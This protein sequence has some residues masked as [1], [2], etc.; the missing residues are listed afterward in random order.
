MD[1]VYSKT[2]LMHP[3][4][5]RPGDGAHQTSVEEGGGPPGELAVTGELGPPWHVVQRGPPERLKN[6][7][8]QAEWANQ[9]LD[10][11][12]PP[13][14]ILAS[15]HYDLGW[16]LRKMLFPLFIVPYPWVLGLSPNG[17][18]QGPPIQPPISLG[19]ASPSQ[20]PLVLNGGVVC[21]GG[22]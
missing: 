9:C 21:D 4:A 8:S 12:G 1:A 17:Q 10:W 18:A 14:A 2:A 20:S 16:L 11:L 7:V 3:C 13:G 5:E 6:S 15:S 22:M 19:D